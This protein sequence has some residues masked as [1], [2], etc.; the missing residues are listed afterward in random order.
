MSAQHTPGPWVWDFSVSVKADG[1]L[2][3]LV[4]STQTNE[5]GETNLDD[6]CR[7]ISAA[8]ELLAVAIRAKAWIAQVMVEEI[9]MPQDRVDNPPE[10]SHLHALTLA[11]AK[12]TGDAA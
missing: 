5:D 1:R 3:A 11:I 2:V 12:A 7:L 6:N 10:G 9:G 8:P 4:Y